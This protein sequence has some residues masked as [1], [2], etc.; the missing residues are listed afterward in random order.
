MSIS[1]PD[2]AAAL[3][4]ILTNCGDIRHFDYSQTDSGLSDDGQLN[5]EARAR[6]SQQ[7]RLKAARRPRDIKFISY[8]PETI[9]NLHL[10]AGRYRRLESQ[11]LYLDRKMV[12]PLLVVADI[13]VALDHYCRGGQGA[14]ASLNVLLNNCDWVVH[15]ILSI[16]PYTRLAASRDSPG[17]DAN[18][19]ITT[20]LYEICGLCA[21][22]YI[23]MVILPTP[24]HTGIKLRHSK[25]IL[26][27]IEEIQQEH[28]AEDPHVID[29][30]L[31]CQIRVLG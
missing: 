3:A 14:P 2:K 28:P 31:A 29:F 18:D 19:S 30:F 26:R 6:V 21:L 12:K 25:I 11:T 7:A 17:Q 5:A 16:A 20:S 23:D 13:T 1:R 15:T 10:L 24:P 27:L 9:Y 4:I 8:S 22:L